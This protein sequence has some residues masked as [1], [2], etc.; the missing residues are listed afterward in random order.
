LR[1]YASPGSLVQVF[2]SNLISFGQLTV[3]GYYVDVG[4]ATPVNSLSR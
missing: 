1:L 3:S 2:P 4:D